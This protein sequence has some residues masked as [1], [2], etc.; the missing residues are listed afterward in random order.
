MTEW[1]PD[2]KFKTFRCKTCGCPYPICTC[3]NYEL[4]TKEAER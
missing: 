4:K 1:E 2:F 3:I